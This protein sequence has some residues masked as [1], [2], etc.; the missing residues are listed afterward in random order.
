MKYDFQQASQDAEKSYGVG[1][2]GDYFVFQKGNNTIQILTPAQVFGIHFLGKGVRSAICYG[3]EKGCP[4]HEAKKPNETDEQY[5][6]RTRVSV[7]YA[8]YVLDKADSEIKLAELPHTVIK[9]IGELQKNPDWAFD[10]LPMPYNITVVY[11]PDAAPADMYKIIP[12]PNRMGL[13]EGFR[14]ELTKKYE[15]FSPIDYVERRK[16][17]QMKEDG[18]DIGAETI[19]EEQGKIEYPTEDINPE[20]IPF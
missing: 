11:N 6:R 16:Q 9:A 13:Q 18:I 15:K 7:K 4:H 10:E 3:K 17:K 8:V 1:G 14:E 20:E 2:K 12:S 5:N 19:V